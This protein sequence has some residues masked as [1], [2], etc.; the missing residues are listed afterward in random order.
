MEK[1]REKGENPSSTTDTVS[2]N[3]TSE[4]SIEDGRVVGIASNRIISMY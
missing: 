2:A 4:Q 1:I 3:V